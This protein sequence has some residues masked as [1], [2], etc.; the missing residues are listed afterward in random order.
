MKNSRH[1]S[2][3]GLMSFSFYVEFIFLRFFIASMAGASKEG[4]STLTSSHASIP[5]QEGAI[6]P[7]SIR[8]QF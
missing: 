5:A 7:F 1:Y 6:L 3:H 8:A 2:A 4:T